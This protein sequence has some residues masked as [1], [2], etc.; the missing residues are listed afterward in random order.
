M[1]PA[2]NHVR[3]TITLPAKVA[4]QVRTFAKS[5]RLSFNDMLVELVE[6]GIESEQRKHQQDF[7]ELAKRFRK[8]TNRDEA[9]LLGDKLGR[10]VFSV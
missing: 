7:F 8:A 10:M 2:D 3:Q 1:S 4:A 5:R 6:K 9:K